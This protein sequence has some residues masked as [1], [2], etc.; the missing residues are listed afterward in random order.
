MLKYREGLRDP[1]MTYFLAINETAK[2]PVVEEEW[3]QWQPN[4]KR[5]PLRCLEFHL[6]EGFVMTN[7]R[8]L[9]TDMRIREK[10]ESAEMLAVNTLV[11]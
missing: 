11:C 10:L 1:L 9:V 2:G 5:E 6:N 4:S 7:E 3:L 8:P